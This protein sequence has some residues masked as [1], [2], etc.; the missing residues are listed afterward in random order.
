VIQR[1]PL[2][3]RLKCIVGRL[4]A[5]VRRRVD[6]PR[7]GELPRGADQFALLVSNGGHVPRRQMELRPVEVADHHYRIA[8]AEAGDDLLPHRRRGGRGQRQPDRRPERVGL[9]AEQQVI[10]PEVAA[11]L[12]D[13]VSLVHR[14][15]HRPQPRRPQVGQLIV[16][17]RDQRRDDDGRPRPQHPG[18]LVDRRLAA[19]GRQH[20]QH[21]T[22]AG[23]R[24]HRAQLP[25]TKLPEAQPLPCQLLDHANTGPN[26]TTRNP[27]FTPTTLRFESP[28]RS[29]R[30]GNH[31]SPTQ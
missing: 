24:L 16:L 18:Q 13:Q 22:P 15:Q 2:P 5:G 14:E 4:R 20:G 8:Q 25:G 30:A 29:G 17:Q 26:A 1:H 31:G 3:G 9:R 28:A 23:Q 6:D 7:P 12:A 21:I 11:P 10:G 27:S 19:A